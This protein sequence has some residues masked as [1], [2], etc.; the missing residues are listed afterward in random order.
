MLFEAVMHK[1]ATRERH[2]FIQ[3]PPSQSVTTQ[4]RNLQSITSDM[5]QITGRMLQTYRGNFSGRSVNK[6]PE[7]LV[8]MTTEPAATGAPPRSPLPVSCSRG[9]N[10]EKE[11]WVK[12]NE[13]DFS[14]VWFHCLI[15]KCLHSASS[16]LSPPGS[17]RSPPHP[18]PPPAIHVRSL[19]S[20]PRPPHHS[21]HRRSWQTVSCG[22]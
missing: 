6:P 7:L 22:D 11:T 18:P 2:L 17:R 13:G 4:W 19:I 21:V 16:A 14:S 8:L 20:H 5:C 12:H 1:T 3:G 9:A 10:E 15:L